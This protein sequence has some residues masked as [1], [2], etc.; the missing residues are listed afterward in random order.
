MTVCRYA[1]RNKKIQVHLWKALYPG[2]SS[3]FV[4]FE[5]VNHVKCLISLSNVPVLLRFLRG[6][7]R[8]SQRVLPRVENETGPYHTGQVSI[9][10]WRTSLHIPSEQFPA[11]RNFDRVI[12]VLGGL[13]TISIGLL[14]SGRPTL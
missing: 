11:K 10:R 14:K 8:A 12:I 6:N 3:I 4:S 13:E 5:T 2:G 7:I 9:Q 1:E